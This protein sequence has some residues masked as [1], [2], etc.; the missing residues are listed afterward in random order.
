MSGRPKPTKSATKP[1][2]VPQPPE[3]PSFAVALGARLASVRPLFRLV[4]LPLAAILVVLVGRRFVGADWQTGLAISIWALTLAGAAMAW[5]FRLSNTVLIFL[6][7]LAAH[8]LSGPLARPTV[9]VGT[10]G[11]GLLWLLPVILPL[12]VALPERGL[13][14]KSGFLRLLL[15]VLPPLSIAAH[16]V[17]GAPTPRWMMVQISPGVWGGP[18]VL[19]VL[20]AG[21]LAYL[22]WRRRGAMEVAVLA[23]LVLSIWSIWLNR[24]P[25][26]LWF[27]TVSAAVVVVAVVQNGYRV[28]F[29][30]ELTG[31]PGRR[32]LKS[33][34]ATMGNRYVIAMLD[35]DHF[36]KFNDTYGHDVGD[37][38]L[39]RV[40][41]VIEGVTGGGQAF[42]YGGEEFT[43]VFPNRT[44]AQALPHLE[45]VREALAATPF[46]VRGPDR[47]EE[48]PENP[49]TADNRQEV[50]ITMS[51]GAAERRSDRSDWEAI[52]KAADEALYASKQ[53]GR[54]KVTLAT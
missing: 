49:Q 36:K 25:E 31:I 13:L 43:I 27:L 42:R 39:C 52:M 1:E 44:P 6:V 16:A 26:P 46:V 30:D 35:V 11:L 41:R 10:L 40:A 5:R 2:P 9:T 33:L 28:A 54:N 4:G 18:A 45:K 53:A 22:A 37:Q 38:V 8:L 50:R 12:L 19:G 3:R 20:G 24:G 17:S 32:A 47:P 51:I 14:G 23:A 21:V 29:H 7:L 15:V 48:K 34:L